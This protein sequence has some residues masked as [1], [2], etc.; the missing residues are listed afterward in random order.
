MKRATYIGTTIDQGRTSGVLT[1]EV[2][3]RLLGWA[4]GAQGP[5]NARPPYTPVPFSALA[6]IDGGPTLL[7]PIRVTPIHDWHEAH[8]AVYE[9]VGQWKR[10][11]YFP[12]D[13]EDMDAAVARECRA[14][15]TGVGVLDAS[16]LGKIDV[17]GPDAGVFLDRMYTNRMSNVAVGSIR[18]GLMLG[19][20]GMVFDDGVAM[21]L[22]EDR[23][24]VTT[25]TGGAAAVMDRFEE[26][27]QTEWTDLRVYCTS[28]TEQW[29]VVAVGGPK[30][31]EVV[32]A[33]GTDIDLDNEAFAFMRF[34][35]GTVAD[36]PVRMCRISFT[37]EL[38]YELHVSPWHA[39]HVWESVMAAGEPFGITP[40]GT[41]AMHVL[42][43]EKGYV[44]VG[45]G[46]RRH[47][48]ARGPRDGLDREPGQG[49]LRRQAFAGAQRHRARGPQA[50]RRS[51]HRGSEHS[52][53]RKE[54]RSSRQRRYRRRRR[55]CWAG[56]PRRT[57]ARPRARASRWR[58]SSVD[59][60]AAVARST[61]CSTDRTMP[62]TVTDPIFYDVEGARRDG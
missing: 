51:S 17:C 52:Y 54:R 49:R 7:D 32:A 57:R 18:Y 42:R 33:A 8:G 62:C 23:Y 12:V 15:R 43:A 36:V 27:L 29:S 31:R 21:R 38:S 24:V 41:E 13:D 22:A 40:Y 39:Q 4:P 59:A 16:T 47:A 60:S 2:V 11:R 55:T 48:D 5:T 10:P 44:I 28:V 9:N 61:P 26:W 45:P 6:G 56:S 25:T 20:D 35:D 19:L 37:G 46:D 3:N 14:V 58:W 53:C 34:R 50:P 30:A 1:A